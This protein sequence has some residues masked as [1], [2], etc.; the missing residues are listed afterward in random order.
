MESGGSQQRN[1]KRG[2]KLE[3]DEKNKKG[4]GKE[5]E[6]RGKRWGRGN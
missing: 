1:Q 3:K 5:V 2:M 4:K 6:N